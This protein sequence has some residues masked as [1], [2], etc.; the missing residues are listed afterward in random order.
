MKLTT[1]VFFSIFFIVS[2]LF[3]LEKIIAEPIPPPLT[4]KILS[5]MIGNKN[6]YDQTYQ[7][8][9]AR[10][11]VAILGFYQGQTGKDGESINT[12]LEQI[13]Q[14][15]PK[16]LLGQYTVLSEA[17]DDTEKTASRERGRKI[18]Q[19]SWWLKN[20][21]GERVQWT[22]QYHAWEV[23]ITEW[24]SPDSD[25]NRYPQWLAQKDYT[26][27]FKETPSLD[28]WY[29][30]NALSRPAVKQADW[31]SDGAD[32]HRDDPAIITAHRR[33]HASHWKEAQRVHPLV[34]LMGNSDDVSSPEYSGKLHGVFMEAVIGASWSM[35]RWKG[36]EAVLDRY[37][38]AM[39]HT[40]EPHIVGFNVRGQKDDF[41]R[42]RYGLTTC[43]LD[44]G[45]FSYTDESV[46]Y[47][48]V[49]WFDEYDIALGNPID[50]PP[51]QP[52]QNG[53]YRREFESGLVL[54]NPSVFSKTVIIEEGFQRIKGV[55][56]PDV[57]NGA[58]VSSITLAGKDGIILTKT[59]K[60]DSEPPKP[61]QEVQIIP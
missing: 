19:E 29:F 48:S 38:L 34:L 13:K 30:D 57:N 17:M 50:P 41:Q 37:R 25:G 36:W 59:L 49:V 56:A 27:F 45:Y 42:M 53:V 40:A 20:A 10:S 8:E 26:V 33:G 47:S 7:K 32:D 22:E 46:G 9:I 11:D 16:I 43:L 52:W 2:Y 61:P 12:I 35:E 24:T 31:D 23:N 5:M 58:L 1:T 51:T 60:K 14:Y 21:S 4:P 39:K 28:I 6:Y 15:N 44:D 55:Q 3:G 18:D 54:A